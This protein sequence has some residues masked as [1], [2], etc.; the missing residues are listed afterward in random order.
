MAG[1]VKDTSKQEITKASQKKLA[2]EMGLILPKNFGDVIQ[3][4]LTQWSEN[5]QLDFP[6]GYSVGNAI[7]SAWIQISNPKFEG[8]S[9]QSIVNSLIN[10][11]VLGLNPTRNQCYFIKMGNEL[12]MMPSYFGKVT[13][14]KRIDGVIDVVADVIYQDTDYEMSVNEF[15][16]ETIKITKPCPLDKRKKEN[17]VGAWCCIFLDTSKGFMYDKY[18]TIMTME[19]IQNVWNMGSSRGKSKAHTDFTNEMAKKS[20]I[21]RCTK[22]FINTLTDD[23]Y[24]VDAYLES[25]DNEYTY[26]GANDEMFQN[27]EIDDRNIKSQK[28]GDDRVVVGI[29]D[30]TERKEKPNP[31]KQP[32]KKEKEVAKSEDMQEHVSAE[33]EQK[34]EDTSSDD[35]LD[36]M[37]GIEDYFN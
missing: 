10:M 12:V 32:K 3:N 14:L 24:F 34:V 11:C 36:F 6:K 33:S 1:T 2:S 8:V 31:K 23:R 16:L 5:S 29:D 13:A 20:V 35:D 19:E 27:K 4:T 30:V 37:S 21:N 17:L 9:N 18:Y 25:V 28:L 7:K 22:M 15:G 26:E